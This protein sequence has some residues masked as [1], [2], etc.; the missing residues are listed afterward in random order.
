MAT[1]QN[2]SSLS[3]SLSAAL[4]SLDKSSY[5]S[6]AMGM[7]SGF[8]NVKDYDDAVAYSNI[9]ATSRPREIHL[10][11]FAS[12]KPQLEESPEWGEVLTLAEWLNLLREEGV[13]DD[14]G[15]GYFSIGNASSD[16]FPI[17]PSQCRERVMY[18]SWATHVVWLTQ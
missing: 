18:P 1:I 14:D 6:K 8:Y 3:N 16:K 12:T 5:Y 13:S 11:S 17:I 15:C 4:M 9:F 10:K 2:T 7:M